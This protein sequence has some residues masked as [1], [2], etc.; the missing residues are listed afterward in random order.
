MVAP[1]SGSPSPRT[2]GSEPPRLDEIAGG[3]PAENAEVTRK[4]FAGEQG[5]A[6]DIS[7][8]NG[9]AAIFVAGGADSLAAGVERAKEAVA[10]GAAADVLERLAARTTEL[11]GSA[12]PE[13]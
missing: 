6:H 10:S 1:R 11:A 13:G 12:D 3:E 8:L 7:V 5:P 4:V 2:S 9:G